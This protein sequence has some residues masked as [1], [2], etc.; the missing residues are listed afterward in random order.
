M[1]TITTG[2]SSSLIQPQ[3]VFTVLGRHIL[4]DAF[5]LVLDLKNSA[6]CYLQDARNGR[7]CLDCFSFVASSALGINHPK[8]RIPEFLEKLTHV[9]L[10]KVSNS[11]MYTP[12]MAQFVDTFARVAKPSYMKH[13]FF[14]D[15]GTLGV[16]NA[17]KAA[18]DWKVQ[19]NFARGHGTE[20]G[21]QVI[22]FKQAFHGRSGYTL[23]LTNTD[24]NKTNYYPKFPWPRI[25]NPKIEFPLN[26]D[27]LER[28][29]NAEDEAVGQIERAFD[30]RPGDIASIL[31]EPIQGEGGDNHFRPEFFQRLRQLAD[32]REAM[33]IFDEVQTGIGLTGAMWAAEHTGVKPD[34]ICFGKKVQVCGFM[35]DSRIDS[36]P[37][38]V[39][40]VQSRIN[41]TWGGN[42]TDMVRSQRI[43]EIIEEDGLIENARRVGA[44]LFGKLQDMGIMH[45]TL[46]T[47]C[48]GIGLMQAFDLPDKEM[49]KRFLD[50]CFR[51]GLLMLPCG[52]RS[53]RVRP[54]L[55]FTEADADR[56]IHIMHTAMKSL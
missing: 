30:E 4:V 44:Y 38:N 35:C 43:L 18:F 21:H 27:N 26:A 20:I 34:M 56:A 54:P 16:E 13:L 39:F 37:K 17:L 8:M 50:N 25:D 28:V 53:V 51:L 7:R 29:R 48:R 9:A 32:E 14:I 31:I 2:S 3:E 23:S 5:D 15:G 36:I 19:S 22:H 46:I 24:P 10:T 52:D 42:L 6:G 55:I 1:S 47:N 45:P 33:L 11:D 40:A 12:E 49:R 41:S